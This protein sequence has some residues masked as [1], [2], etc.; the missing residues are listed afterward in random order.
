M[1]AA[2]KA[3][4]VAYGRGAGAAESV[5]GYWEQRGYPDDAPVRDG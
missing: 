2:G 5:P 4:A 3:A 1:A